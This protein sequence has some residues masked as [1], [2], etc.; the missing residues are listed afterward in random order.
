MNP[1]LTRSW[2]DKRFKI[3]V[4]DYCK[5][6]LAFGYGDCKPFAFLFCPDCHHIFILLNK[7]KLAELLDEGMKEYKELFGK[8]LQLEEKND[9][10]LL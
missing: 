8:E 3:P 4:C 1:L 6:D 2:M 9:Y 10:W 7:R 5:K